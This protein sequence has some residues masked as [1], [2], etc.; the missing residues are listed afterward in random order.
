MEGWLNF[1]SRGI[2]ALQDCRMDRTI[3]VLEERFVRLTISRL[4][5]VHT[6]SGLNGGTPYTLVNPAS[7][8]QV[9]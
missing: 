8:A 5:H 9:T 4:V 1:H 7:D 2:T 6:S 3:Q